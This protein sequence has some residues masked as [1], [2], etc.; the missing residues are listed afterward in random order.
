MTVDFMLVIGRFCV[1]RC[2]VGPLSKR[3]ARTLNRK[4]FGHAGGLNIYTA[5]STRLNK[6]ITSPINLHVVENIIQYIIRI[7]V[8]HNNR[9]S[10]RDFTRKSIILFQSRPL[11]FTS[12]LRGYVSDPTP[13]MSLAVGQCEIDRFR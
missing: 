2:I 5:Q 7:C 9:S 3:L 10:S 8:T 1:K 4:C 6:L 12:S 11:F 13:L